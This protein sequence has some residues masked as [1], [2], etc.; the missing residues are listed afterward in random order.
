MRAKASSALVF[1]VMLAGFAGTTQGAHTYPKVGN[2]F[3]ESVSMDYCQTLSKWD[4]VI[5][6]RNTPELTPEVLPTLRRLNPE[7]KILTYYPVAAVW[8][9]YDTM[10]TAARLYGEKVQASDWWLYDNKGN[11]V[12]DASGSWFINFSTKCPEDAQGGTVQQWLA[13]HIADQIIVGGPWDGILLDIMFDNAWWLNNTDW[14][15]DPPA[16]LD[17]DRDGIADDPDSV[18]AWWRTGILSFLDRLRQ[19]IGWSYILV[20]NGKHCLSD[21][22]NGGIREDF[23]HM[24]GGWEEN[25]FSSYGYLT[26]CRELLDYP[27]SCVLMM[28]KW[29]ADG[30]TQYGPRRTVSYERFLRYT[31]CSAL[32]GDGYYFLQSGNSDLWWEDYYDLD[33]GAPTSEAYLDSLWNNMYRR[34]SPVWRRDFENA[35]IYCNPYDEYISSDAGSLGPQDGLIRTHGVP[36]DVAIRFLPDG[37]CARSFDQR[38]RWLTFTFTIDNSAENAV[39]ASVWAN[40][41]KGDT[42][43]VSC[44]P[45]EYLV[46]AQDTTVEKRWFRIP[47]DLG[48]GDYRLQVM[49]GGHD[50]TEVD[51][52]TMTVAKVIGFRKKMIK[53]GDLD[54]MSVNV[55]PLPVVLGDGDL[56]V[57]VEPESGAGGIVGLRVYD[58]NGRLVRTASEGGIDREIELDIDTDG[59]G[60]PTA[61]GV[62]FI[63]VDLKD[64]VLTRKIIVLRR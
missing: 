19:E 31:L 56:H 6:S 41:S 64:R 33:L 2:Y 3:T 42:I 14:F 54:G 27:M 24:H 9:S 39:F 22:L 53:G 38:E 25:M 51:R 10:D 40:L 23:P 11:R 5:L 62:Y 1:A 63:A 18:Y 49:V 35:T 57:D 21:Y 52:D 13:E 60:H 12:G 37:G 7:I 44:S 15:A 29:T 45:F 50:G 32:L 58:V 47:P 43:L 17:L 4:V 55:Y 48:P 28:C 61:P 46:G 8:A 59:N 16:M 20:G 36:S 30:S 34:Y 26:L